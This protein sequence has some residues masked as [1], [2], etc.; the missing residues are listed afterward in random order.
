VIVDVDYR[1]DQ[2]DSAAAFAREIDRLLRSASLAIGT[3]E[4]IVA[5]TAARDADAGTA[6]LLAT[7]IEALILKRGARGATIFRR[8]TAPVDV[9]PF[10]VDVLNVLGAGDA[11]AS[12][13]LFGFLNDWPLERAVRMGNACGAIVV[14]RHGYANFMPT[15]DEVEEFVASRGG[16]E[17]AQQHA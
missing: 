1:G 4:E 5:A 9:P 8:D 7:G 14:T 12:G 11:F 3:E 13:F 2:W 10:P 17:W 15:R 6:A 16:W